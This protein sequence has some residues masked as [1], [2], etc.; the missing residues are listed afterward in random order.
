[1]LPLQGDQ[2]DLRILAEAEAKEWK[3]LPHHMR[4]M[5]AST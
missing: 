4:A 5:R 1:M 2:A 3:I